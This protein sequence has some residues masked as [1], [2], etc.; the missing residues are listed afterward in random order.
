MGPNELK[1][2]LRSLWFYLRNPQRAIG[3]KFEKM[4]ERVTERVAVAEA[5]IREEM[6]QHLVVLLFRCALGAIAGVLVLIAG[7][8]FLI[9]LWL[10]ADRFVGPIAGSIALA[11]IFFA[12]S[13]PPAI[14]LYKDLRGTKSESLN[15]MKKPF[16]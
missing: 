5:H 1:S 10:A 6:H 15:Q 12:A 2:R 8:Y 7:I 16:L 9:G 11:A 4:E 13:L 14:I 3:E